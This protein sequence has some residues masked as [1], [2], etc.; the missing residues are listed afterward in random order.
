MFE[1]LDF[2][3]CPSPDIEADIAHYT[4]GL[5]GE[6]VFAIEAF[7]TRVAQVAL[8]PG[9]PAV[10]LAQHLDGDRPILIFRVPSL[11]DAVAELDG[12]GV[13]SGPEFGFPHGEGVEVDMPGPQRTAI[14]ELTRP[15]RGASLAGRK[16]F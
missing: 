16:D 4:E 5:G 15:E 2:L 1:Q 7:G 13:T 6:L 12:R 10:L 8:A 9:A 14:Y 11:G 3:Y